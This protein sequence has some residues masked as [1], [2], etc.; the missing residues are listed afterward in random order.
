MIVCGWNRYFQLDKN[1]NNYDASDD[2]IVNPA[3]KFHADPASLLSFSVSF[4][5]TVWITRNGK[6][7]AIGDNGDGIISGSLPKK[8]FTEDIGISLY[9]Q[10]KKPYKFISVVCGQHYT[11]YLVSEDSA[12]ANIMLVY[13]HSKQTS[14]PL[15]VN[16]GN[17][18]PRALYG[19]DDTSGVID[20]EGG[21]LIITKT[22]LIPH[23]T[24]VEPLFLPNDEKPVKLACCNFFILALSKSGK[25]FET[26]Y[27][28]NGL[29]KFEEVK[30][31]ASESI[32]DISGSS[33]F[34]LAVT[35]SGRVFGRGSNERCQLGI[36]EK[37][38]SV[39]KFTLIDS[40]KDLK[41][42]S[43][44]TG[45]FHSIF[46]TSESKMF[47]CG[48]NMRGQLFV[49]PK[50]VVFPPEEVKNCNGFDF[51]VTGGT[52]SVAFAAIDHPQ[53]FS[54]RII[55]DVEEPAS[56]VE[57][58]R[59]LLKEK[60]KEIAELKKEISIRNEKY[61]SLKTSS[62][63]D[64]EKIKLLE[65]ENVELKNAQNH[66]L[67]ILGINDIESLNKVKKIGRGATSEVFEVQQQVTK[68]LKVLNSEIFKLEKVEEN[69]ND[70]DDKSEIDIDVNKV[71][72][73]FTE[74][75]VLHKIDHPNIIK[76]YGF[77]FGDKTHEPAI[78]LEYCEANLRKRIK[79]LSEAE[80]ISV[81]VD[82]SS[83]MKR[84]HSLGIIHR[85]LKLENI[86]LDKN[87]SVKVSDFGL[88][89][90]IK[91]DDETISRTQMAGT[92]KY[93]APELLQERKDY[94]EKVDVYA[95]GVVV[96]KILSKGEYPDV[97]IADI[98]TGKQAQIPPYFTQFAA[99]L[100][101][102]CWS[103]KPN[104]RP[105]FI[106]ICDRLK[107]NDHKLI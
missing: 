107:G 30:E 48:W 52:S 79:K 33:D 95:F 54:N 40:L 93:M 41:I 92:L 13:C 32:V 81:I 73:F 27:G 105:S 26:K 101:K 58:L 56:E 66:P 77:F 8:T 102:D 88:C 29:S 45:T 21:I 72:S 38:K 47:V 20:T 80:R 15:F 34:C 91:N 61:L 50:T 68:A 31:L 39:P 76:T 12:T 106:E 24:K 25:V 28:K 104:D 17:R 3:R 49:P 78:L 98:V 71:R 96:F 89:T 64:K 22:T 7:W 99:K 53:N 43:V 62:K 103:F 70:E 87:N 60:E 82:I 86:L 14:N 97:S 1:S 19:G 37:M 83:A 36:S 94:N 65:R 85:D 46:K 42:V 67:P 35:K 55:E 4:R 59:K 84:I 75:E 57:M 90:F 74:C 100:I 6:L 11:L 18:V 44:F 16:I 2:P 9:N 63:K 5:Q 51:C 10:Q 23:T 69:E